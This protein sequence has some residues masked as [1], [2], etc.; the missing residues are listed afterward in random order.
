MRALLILLMLTITW[1][2]LDFCEPA[3]SRAAAATL[4]SAEIGD[5][6]HR[7]AVPD[8]SPDA[9]LGHHHCP[10][11]ADLVDV[12]MAIAAILTEQLPSPRPSAPLSSRAQAPPAEPPAA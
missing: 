12:P 5:D 7:H 8:A 6:G 10:L 1:C 11:A 3:Y 4:A 9:H 2:G